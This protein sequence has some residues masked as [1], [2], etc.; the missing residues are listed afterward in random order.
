MLA[1]AFELGLNVNAIDAGRIEE[2]MNVDLVLGEFPAQN[3][4]IYSRHVVVILR[5]THAVDVAEG[6]P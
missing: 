6:Q 3:R 2:F 5:V 4:L 1:L